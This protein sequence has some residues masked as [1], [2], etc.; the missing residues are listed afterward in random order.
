MKSLSQRL[1]QVL[2]LFICFTLNGCSAE[3]RFV[4]VGGADISAD[5]LLSR[6]YTASTAEFRNA[7]GYY[8]VRSYAKRDEKKDAEELEKLQHFLDK[9]IEERIANDKKFG[10]TTSDEHIRQ[11]RESNLQ[12][13]ALHEKLQDPFNTRVDRYTIEG[14]KYRIERV[15]VSNT[16]SLEKI[17][18]DILAGQIDF[19]NP[20]VITWNGKVTAEII[21]SNMETDDAGDKTPDENNPNTMSSVVYE[22]IGKLPEFMDHG[23]D[24]K[25]NKFLDQYRRMGLPLSVT[26][27]TI[28]GEQGLL[29]RIGDKNSI[30]FLIETC[31]LPSKG[32][33]ITSGRV[34]ARGVVM[35]ED[36]YRDFVK[37]NDGSWLPTRIT[38]TNY[39]IDQQG[40]PYIATKKEMLA[41]EIP[42][43]NVKLPENVFDIANTRE[44]QSLT[45]LFIDTG[46]PKN[47]A[48][49][50][51]WSALRWNFALA[52]IIL[53][54]WALF[55]LW[56][57][58]HSRLGLFIIS[59]L[60]LSVLCGCQKRNVSAKTIKYDVVLTDSG[61]I[62][63]H[64]SGNIP[65]AAP[66]GMGIK[67]ELTIK[68]ECSSKVEAMTVA[69]TCGC[70]E[71]LLQNDE[72][73]PG[74]TVTL[75]LFFKPEDTLL[76][77]NVEVNV[78]IR[79]MTEPERPFVIPVLY[80]NTESLNGFQI[81]TVPHS[82]SI[83]AV[84]SPDLKIQE[85]ITFRFGNKIDASGISV[86]VF[87]KRM[88]LRTNRLH[89][90]RNDKC[91]R[92]IFCVFF[93]D[94][95]KTFDG[96]LST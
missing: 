16:D 66:V 93:L 21:V 22:E 46:I 91:F 5:E 58:W 56:R 57:A 37:V 32:Y 24:I 54:V 74:E 52:G 14:N 7:V 36:D 39:H 86:S 88:P 80:S 73:L 9:S 67:K 59:A 33:V 60:C 18:Q 20:N 77:S 2:F 45:P 76:K 48:P 81:Y 84:R 65:I 4:E 30:I 82:I 23:R 72:I 92:S 62:I 29:L 12:T 89:H 43:L 6:I 40:V 71:A 11:I 34:K 19:A 83:D 90:V 53:I 8:V 96:N 44:F 13:L 15:N 75:A 61:V 50:K 70:S 10:V 25:D 47:E 94:T 95:T 51:V 17:R 69:T 78:L 26:S 55:R 35:A 68:S 3:P 38:R 87:E 49:K 64:P 79:H 41:I 63:D 28:D 1:F 85:Q 27:I 42:K 31:V